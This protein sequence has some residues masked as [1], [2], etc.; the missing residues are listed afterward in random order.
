MQ[1]GPPAPYMI[2]QVM[3]EATTGEM[4]C[5]FGLPRVSLGEKICGLCCVQGGESL[6][7]DWVGHPTKGKSA[8]RNKENT[9]PRPP[10]LSFMA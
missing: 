5:I 6:K 10:Q 9:I 1:E 2:A 7:R 3:V 8:K 4:G